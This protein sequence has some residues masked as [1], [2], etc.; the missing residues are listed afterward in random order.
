LPLVPHASIVCDNEALGYCFDSKGIK[1][2]TGSRWEVST[3]CGPFDEDLYQTRGPF[4][5]AFSDVT[6]M[7]TIGNSNYNALEV[8][9]RHESRTLELMAGYTY[10]KSLDNASSI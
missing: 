7:S 9:L 6:W 2:I 5:A 10:S 4:S 1:L 3:G 8:N